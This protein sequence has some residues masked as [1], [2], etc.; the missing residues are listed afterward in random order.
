[1]AT[2]KGHLNMMETSVNDDGHECGTVHCVGGWYAIANNLHLDGYITFREGADK[3]AF[4][5]GLN[6]S[7]YLDKWATLNPIIWGNEYGESIFSS[8]I[9]YNNACS[10]SEVIT[11]LE[12]VRDRSPE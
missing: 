8:R 9:A 5:L 2:M 12:G 7:Y 4:D 6:V 11:H 10:L 3:M 1:M